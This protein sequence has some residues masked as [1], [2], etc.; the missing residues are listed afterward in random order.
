MSVFVLL[1]VSVS[2]Y[3]PFHLTNKKTPKLFRK[4]SNLQINP[5][6]PL[7][8][9]ENFNPKKHPKLKNPPLKLKKS[10]F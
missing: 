9:R 2:V 6:N 10:V 4:T 7:K 3:V 8:T 1:F 5:L